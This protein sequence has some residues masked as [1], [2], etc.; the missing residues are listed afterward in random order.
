MS[1]IASMN[2]SLTADTTNF[3]KGM[4]DAGKGVDALTISLGVGL[5]RLAEFGVE[6]AKEGI[7]KLVEFT[8]ASMEHVEAATELSQRIGTNVTDLMALE[9]AAT[10]AGGSADAVAS[11]MEKFV[12]ILGGA[13]E[14]ASGGNA[15][16]AIEML[17][18]D[19]DALKNTDKATD[20]EVIATAMDGIT[21]STERA[22][23]ETSLFGKSGQQLDGLM[24]ELAEG[25]L[26]EVADKALKTGEALRDVDA[27]KVAIA[28]NSLKELDGVI[29]G[30]G[31][32][33]AV[34][35][36]PYIDYVTQQIIDF[37][38]S[39]GGM[40]AM[41]TNAFHNVNNAIG[42]VINS[43]SLLKAGWYGFQAVVN[44]VADFVVVGPLR[45]I[46]YAIDTIVVSFENQINVLISGYNKVQS[47]AATAQRDYAQ[48]QLDKIKKEHPTARYGDDQGTDFSYY[49]SMRQQ[50]QKAIDEKAIKPISVQDTGLS[51]FFDKIH[52][53]LQANAAEGAE[54]FTKNMEDWLKGKG[55][56]EWMK[57]T[58]DIASQFEKKAKLAAGKG[59]P[60]EED[61]L[62]GSIKGGA[63]KQFDPSQISVA[64]LSMASKAKQVVTDPEAANQRQQQIDIA[65][66]T[67][68]EVKSGKTATVGKG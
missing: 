26:T 27:Y 42:W 3:M 2:A 17:G 9:A 28:S 30:V 29:S 49:E 53:E 31:N 50:S 15:V 40:Q 57:F 44:K 7:S 63:F 19:L 18:L 64:G 5:E 25:S 52:T 62:A 4:H 58:D 60:M 61:G 41:V 22:Y 24:K 68:K 37:A 54:G 66:Q 39:S 1:T 45:A 36:S 46:S 48:S 59:R 6:L 43:I 65:K 13:E 32:S 34:A 38:N 20:L 67:L 55:H 33:I 16:K 11:S 8:K 10:K 35:L 23:I 12:K 14:S 51:S 21:N 56:D 47:L